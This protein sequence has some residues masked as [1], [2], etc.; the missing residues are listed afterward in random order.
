MSNQ[1]VQIIADGSGEETNDTSWHYVVQH[2]DSPR[3]LCS[4]E[5]FGDAEGS[6]IYR[7]K[8]VVRGGI[9]CPKCLL[10]IKQ[11]KAKKL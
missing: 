8:S 11:F 9:T 1:V 7:S 10:I 6:A 2:G 5:V 4:G 3:T